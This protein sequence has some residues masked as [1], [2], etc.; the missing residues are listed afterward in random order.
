MIG[1][2]CTHFG[3]RPFEDWIGP[4]SKEFRHWEV[5]SEAEHSIIGNVP[6]IRG[7]IDD[8]GTSC[9]VHAPICDWNIGA[10]SDRLRRASLEETLE[11]I[12]ASAELGAST[13]TVHPGLSSMAVDG[14][15]QQAM[16][17]ARESLKAIDAASRDA[18]V[19]VAIENMPQ[20]PFFLGRTAA[21]LESLIDGTDLGVCFD[22][23]HANTAGQ[24]DEMI[25]TFG[26]RIVNVHIHDNNGK[27]DEHLTIGDGSIDFPRVL[28]R[29]GWYGGNWI[30]ES[31]NF[32][33]RGLEVRD[34]L[35]AL[36]GRVSPS[37]NLRQTGRA[38][39]HEGEG[40]AGHGHQHGSVHEHGQ[41]VHAEVERY[42]DVDPEADVQV[43]HDQPADERGEN[44]PQ[45]PSGL[46]GESEHEG[47]DYYQN[48]G[49]AAYAEPSEEEQRC[50]PPPADQGHEGH[51]Y[52][53]VDDA[54]DHLLPHRC[55][56]ERQEGIR[57]GSERQVRGDLR[58][59]EVEQADDQVE[60]QVGGEQEPEP[61]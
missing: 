1:V 9:S 56:G 61:E 57:H 24:I 19:V 27:R 11:T 17:R 52:P 49:E 48:Q 6:R 26:D 58:S 32:E 21:D 50:I 28:G 22:I 53:D 38:K 23:G 46:V 14:M 39:R 18:G 43:S 4:I 59:A 40:H 10:L 12:S 54:G 44:L 55:I 47:R 5:F 35:Q 20:V 34:V 29:M 2:S 41:V 7:L 36:P 45:T 13:V 31:K 8:A 51:G 33:C 3:S 25:D 15:G 60:Q 42:G 37:C 16:A 30:I